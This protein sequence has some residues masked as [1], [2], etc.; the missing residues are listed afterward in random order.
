M[1]GRQS[2]VNRIVLRQIRQHRRIARCIAPVSHQVADDAE[3]ADYLHACARHAVV[4]NVTDEFR[5]CAGGFDVGPYAVAGL[6]EREGAE[7]RAF[8]LVRLRSIG[9]FLLAQQDL[10]TSVV[11]P[12]RITWLLPVASMA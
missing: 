2:P 3:Q 10:Q 1:R 9:R 11:I 5:G 12:A 6:A 8:E 7:G 4:R